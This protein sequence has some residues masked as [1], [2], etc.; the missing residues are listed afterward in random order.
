MANE[1][2]GHASAGLTLYA[3]LVNSDGRA[4]DTTLAAFV[5]IAPADWANYDLAMTEATAGIYLASMPTVVAD[6]YSFVVYQRV[7][8]TPAVTD[9]QKDDGTLTWNGSAVTVPTGGVILS[10]ADYPAIRAALDVSL[11]TK[12]L[13]DDVI[14]MDIYQGTAELEILKRDPLALT[15]TGNDWTHV[16]TA[17]ILY[18]ASLIAGG[19]VSRVTSESLPGGGYN[20][21][22]PAV[23]WAKRAETL[24]QRTAEH[25][26]AVLT[27]A[28]T[29]STAVRPTFFG[30]ARGTRGY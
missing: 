14:A 17:A 11:G 7:G 26:A 3:V 19:M 23:D 1:L 20:Y 29:A 12:S 13:P 15:R 8:S 2:Q 22:R 5:T 9:T 18:C 25:M 6:V 16:H 21:S 10:S 4:W 30:V 27:P 24:A 28:A